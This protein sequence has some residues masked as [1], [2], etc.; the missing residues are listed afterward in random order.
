MLEVE[1]TIIQ[2]IAEGDVSDEIDF[3]VNGFL[4]QERGMGLTACQPSLVELDNGSKCIRF[5]ID[6]TFVDSNSNNVMG[7]GQLGTDIGFVGLIYVSYDEEDPEDMDLLFITPKDQIDMAVQ[8]FV[9]DPQ[10]YPPF[11]RRRGKY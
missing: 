6:Y 7:Y 11:E 10:K 1:P 5:K 9:N 3:A 8:K 4:M 2:T